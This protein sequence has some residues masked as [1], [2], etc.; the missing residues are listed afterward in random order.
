MLRDVACAH[1]FVFF[2]IFTLKLKKKRSLFERSCLAFASRPVKR[3]RRPDGGRGFLD[4]RQKANA[5]S[6]SGA[7]S[8]WRWVGPG[9][10]GRRESGAGIQLA[11]P[12][13]PP[14]IPPR[15]GSP[16]A[17]TPVRAGSKRS[18]RPQRACGSALQRRKKVK[19][20]GPGEAKALGP[21]TS[22]TQ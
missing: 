15:A 2:E 17:L 8:P 11:G 21:Q 3:W 13:L 5:W 14:T 12:A 22:V 4:G 1:V 10:P 6:G 9:A 7:S 20:R 18:P 19:G 16:A